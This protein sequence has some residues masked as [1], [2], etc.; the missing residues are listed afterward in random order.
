[1]KL[2]TMSLKDLTTLQAKVSDAI[3]A[4]KKRERNRVKSEIVALAAK[5]GLSVKD[6]LGTR[7]YKPATIKF[8]NPTKPD[9]TWTGRGRHP[10]WFDKHGEEKCRVVA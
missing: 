5:A 1:M 3:E 2:D 6:V 10:H 8:R 4:A 7:K 9:Q